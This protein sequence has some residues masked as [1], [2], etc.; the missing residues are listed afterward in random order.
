MAK[1]LLRPKDELQ[2]VTVVMNEEA[3]VYGNNVL[4]PYLQEQCSNTVT[5][6]VRPLYGSLAPAC[7]RAEGSTC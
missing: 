1:A 5:P 2:L 4:A 7:M 3:V 6:V